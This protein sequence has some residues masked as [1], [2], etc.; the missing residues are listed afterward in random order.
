MSFMADLA[1][2]W[3]QRNEVEFLLQRSLLYSNSGVAC[4]KLKEY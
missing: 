3:L 1:H 4:D 2:S